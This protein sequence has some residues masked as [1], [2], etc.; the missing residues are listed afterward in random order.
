MEQQER[1]RYIRHLLI[2]PLKVKISNKSNLEKTKTMDASEG[3]LL[4]M[5]KK[6][7]NP[8]TTITIEI[9]LYDKVFKVKAKVVHSKKTKE[10][11]MYKIGVSFVSYADAFKVKLV[12][13]M[14]LIE[15]YRNLRS[16]QSGKDISIKEAS[17]EWIDR[18]SER[19][20]KLY[21]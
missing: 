3:G 16:F 15:E 1:R 12:E 5:S 13:Q 8:G 17:K 18:Y 21:W 10:E 6:N 14:Y 4:F 2:N 19:F 7:V 9:P 11:K 20:S